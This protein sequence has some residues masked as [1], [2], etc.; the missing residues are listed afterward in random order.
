MPV[1]LHTPEDELRRLGGPS[2]LKERAARSAAWT[3]RASW[4]P[5]RAPARCPPT[6]VSI[7]GRLRGAE[8]LYVRG[9]PQRGDAGRP[10]VRLIAAD[11]APGADLAPEPNYRR[12]PDAQ[13]TAG[14]PDAI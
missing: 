1:D 14:A 3:R 4:P 13:L 2:C 10:P 12:A 7:V 11:L 9:D 8:W 5:R 6:S